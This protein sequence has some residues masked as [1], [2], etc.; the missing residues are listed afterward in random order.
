MLNELFPSWYFSL[1]TTKSTTVHVGNVVYNIG[2]SQYL[3][4]RYFQLGIFVSLCSASNIFN[5]FVDISEYF[6][7]LNLFSFDKSDY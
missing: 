6:N 4:I 2:T 3:I 5:I 1:I 7:V